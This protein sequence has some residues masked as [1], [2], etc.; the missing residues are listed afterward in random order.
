MRSRCMEGANNSVSEEAAE[1]V[2][3]T[4]P[5][6]AASVTLMPKDGLPFRLHEL[7]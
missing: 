3:H 4:P 5:R 6:V 7:S 2:G 1:Y